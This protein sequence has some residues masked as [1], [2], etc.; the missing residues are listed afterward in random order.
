VKYVAEEVM[1]NYKIVQSQSSNKCHNN[2]FWSGSV[3]AINSWY[4]EYIYIIIGN[5]FLKHGSELK[6]IPRDRVGFM[7]L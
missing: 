3:F 2:E 7:V 4:L 6:I 1:N 5:V